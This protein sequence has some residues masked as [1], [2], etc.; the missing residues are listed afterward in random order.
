MEGEWH[1]IA[2]SARNALAQD[3]RV[4]ADKHH[5][6]NW[7]GRELSLFSKLFILKWDTDLDTDLEDTQNNC[8]A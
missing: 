3:S 7:D 4:P 1:G 5:L 8:A 2:L 6:S